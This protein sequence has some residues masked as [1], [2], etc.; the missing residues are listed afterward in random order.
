M[1]APNRIRLYREF[2]TPALHR[3]FTQAAGVSLLV[4]Y[5]EA[6]IIGD[7]S[8][9]LLFSEVYIWSVPKEANLNWVVQGRSWERQRLNERPIYL[10]SLYLGLAILQTL[11][12]LGFD[13]DE[14]R[15][16]VDNADYR[17]A[18]QERPQIAITP[19]EHM[20]SKG[21]GILREIGT[22]S[23]ISSVIG[24]VIY[25]LTVRS[26]AWRTSLACARFLHWDIPS[27]AELSYI[28]PYHITLIFRSLISGFCLLLLWRGSNLAFTAY[29]AQEPLKRGQP[30]TQES[31]DPNGSLINGLKSRKQITFAFWELAKISRQF[32][33]RRVSIFEDI[34][35]QAGPAWSQISTECLKVIQAI[36]TR[37]SDYEKGPTEQQ[38][39]LKPEQLQTLPRLGAPLK[40]EPGVFLKPPPPSSK[41]EIVER[42]LGTFA[43]SYGSSPA[44]PAANGSPT[45]QKSKQYLEDARKKILSPEQQQTLSVAHAQ[46]TFNIYLTSFLAS[47]CGKPF[48]QT[49]GRRVRG[50]AFGQPFSEVSMIFD[51]VEALTAMAT[52]SI[53]EDSYG[54][55]ARD[56]PSILK[57][58]VSTH[59]SLEKLTGTLQPHWT[60]VEF[61]EGHRRVGDVE[62]VLGALRFG[63]GEIVKAFGG[64]AAE[65]GLEEK[66][67]RVAKGIAGMEEGR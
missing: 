20:K 17:P 3:R 52:A 1:P 44:P 25:S 64:F 19:V 41:R 21:S 33:E 27:T 56:I 28:P 40:E 2:L 5:V 16:S 8:S 35:R 4:C 37:I 29:V 14:I 60:D 53:Q 30:L 9:S 39:T 15:G 6:V 66:D 61:Q 57:T 23:L 46:S 54:K 50:I 63:L 32:P 45:I 49:F 26:T 10:R 48:R 62:I 12:H 43:Q 58:F 31:N 13:Y 47:W 59:Q 24:P 34:D 67:V 55:V 51:A 7:K 65:I 22:I 18:P 11:L 42:K 38:T 36:T